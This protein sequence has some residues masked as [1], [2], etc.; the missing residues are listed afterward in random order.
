MDNDSG[1]AATTISLTARGQDD[2][3]HHLTLPCRWVELVQAWD[4]E[5][6]AYF[7]VSGVD[8]DALTADQIRDGSWEFLAFKDASGKAHRHRI[9]T[10]TLGSSGSIRLMRAH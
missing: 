8:P 4:G 2:H 10:V 5:S 7:L 3:Q 6:E 1:W 9:G